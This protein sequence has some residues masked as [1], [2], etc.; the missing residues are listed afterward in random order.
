V[1]SFKFQLPKSVEEGDGERESKQEKII[2]PPLV[3]EEEGWFWI[4]GI[5]FD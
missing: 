3:E 5:G 1:G 4:G 2:E